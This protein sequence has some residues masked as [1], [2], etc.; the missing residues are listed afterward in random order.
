MGGIVKVLSR[1]KWAL[2]LACLPV[3]AGADEWWQGK[4]AWDKAWCDRV[5][6]IGRVTPAPIAITP[7]EV[8]GYENS[9]AIR[10]AQ[11]LRGMAA[12]RLELKCRSEGNTYEESRLIMRG[13]D[14]RDLGKEIW[15][16][17]GEGEPTRFFRCPEINASDGWWYKK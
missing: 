12:V 15:I 11:P 7:T 1:L 13:G 10:R 14:G 4:W 9:C 8:L 16:W 5:N 3:A 17:F 6:Q 2:V